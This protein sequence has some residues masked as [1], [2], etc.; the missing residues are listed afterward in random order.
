MPAP[1]F[2]GESEGLGCSGTIWEVGDFQWGLFA[3]QADSME[4]TTHRPD[5]ENENPGLA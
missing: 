3:S 1:I 2:G 5:S 4:A